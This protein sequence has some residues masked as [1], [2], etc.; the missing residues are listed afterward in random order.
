MFSS[1]RCCFL[2]DTDDKAI[3]GKRIGVGGSVEV[4]AVCA[5][6]AFDGTIASG[7]DGV[8]LDAGGYGESI[9]GG[10]S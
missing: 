4:N 3:S 2:F 6:V 1:E 9:V 5:A 7:N 8:F 10:N